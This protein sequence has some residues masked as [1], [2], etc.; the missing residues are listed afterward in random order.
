MSG[1]GQIPAV[2]IVDCVGGCGQP[3][4]VVSDAS[5]IGKAVGFVEQGAERLGT[6]LVVQSR[7]IG[8]VAPRYCACRIVQRYHPTVGL[9]RADVEKDATAAIVV[10]DN[11]AYMIGG[12]NGVLYLKVTDLAHS[13]A[14][15]WIVDMVVFHIVTKAAASIHVV[16]MAFSEFGRRPPITVD[17]I[18]KF[19]STHHL[20]RSVDFRRI[21]KKVTQLSRAR[22][23][24]TIVVVDRPSG[25]KG[26][27]KINVSY[28][29]CI[30]VAV[31]VVHGISGISDIG[32]FGNV[33]AIIVVVAP[34]DG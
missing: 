28:D 23:V 9:V 15:G 11:I 4:L 16:G 2:L 25:R 1:R 34:L 30:G 22:Q 31:Q 12:M 20:Q 3:V 17:V 26:K 14:I 21:R 24:P 5:R 10:G 27:V 13:D 7:H 19:R 8:V 29:A 6:G 18:R 32:Q 33:V